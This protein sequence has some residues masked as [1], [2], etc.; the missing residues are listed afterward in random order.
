M[1]LNSMGLFSSHTADHYTPPEIVALAVKT[2]GEIDLDPCS[3]SRE[4]PNIPAREHYTRA[5]NGLLLPW[6]GR[7][8]LNPPYG[9]KIGDWVRKLRAEYEAGN[10]SSAI[11]LVPARVDTKWFSELYGYP[12]CFISG[13]LRFINSRGALQGAAPFPSAI[14]YLGEEP[15]RFFREFERMGRLYLP[16]GFE[17]DSAESERAYHGL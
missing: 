12:V 5:E 7:V 13:R 6:I 10:T 15:A 1:A 14:V 2:L 8:Y 3:N 4:A 9:R 16:I 17:R 11:A